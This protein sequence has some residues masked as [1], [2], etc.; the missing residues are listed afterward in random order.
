[1]AGVPGYALARPGLHVNESKALAALILGLAG[2]VGSIYLALFGLALGIAGL[3]LG[4]MSQSGTKRGLSTAGIVASSLAVLA[5]MGVWTY[6]VKHDPGLQKAPAQSQ[7]ITAPAVSASSLTTPCY[8]AG[9]V[10]RLNVSNNSGSCDMSAFNGPTIGSSSNAYKVYA[11]QSSI[12]TPGN[13][14]GLVKPAIEKDI[15]A[16]LP[17]FTINSEQVTQFAGSPAYAVNSSNK[18]LG[19]TVVEAAV[20]HRVGNGDNLF[21]LVHAVNGSNTDLSTIEA[22]WQWK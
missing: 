21:I 19:V 15:K 20:L 13:F 9:F 22:Q 7:G 3:V 16:N 14:D 1:M 6:A 18:A 12:A 2:I 10:D 17:S 8:S 5:S 11:D 4:T